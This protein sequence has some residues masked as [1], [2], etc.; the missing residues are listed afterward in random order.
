MGYDAAVK[1]NEGNHILTNGKDLQTTSPPKKK[2]QNMYILMPFT[3]KTM[4]VYT[5]LS[6]MMELF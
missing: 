4:K 2:L 3:K 1:K 6:T 5:G